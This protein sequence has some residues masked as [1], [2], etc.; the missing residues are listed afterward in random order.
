MHMTSL[1]KN[2]CW[3]K[4]GV[5]SGESIQEILARKERERLASG[6]MFLWGIGNSVGLAIRELILRE[7]RPQV[8]FSPMRSKPKAVDA[9]PGVV[10]NWTS[11]IDLDGNGWDIPR[12][13]SVVSR[14]SSE[15][16]RRKASHYALVCRSDQPLTEAGAGE[17][18]YERL[19]N[20]LSMSRLGYSQ[21][22]AVVS[23]RLD[24]SGV[25]QET[26]YPVGLVADL[27]FP[28]F[29]KLQ[30]PEVFGGAHRSKSSTCQSLNLQA[31][32]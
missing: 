1:P 6:G 25:D 21:V 20:M 14:G 4:Y 15:A 12:T 5:E 24:R 32:L 31:G 19:L 8:V 23:R 18:V 22:T 26:S 7:I 28:Y 30:D 27:V 11:A 13:L 29:V 16:G 3:T 2:F 9:A 10:L 17:V